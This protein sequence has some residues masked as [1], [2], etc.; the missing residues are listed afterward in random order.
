M[1]SVEVCEDDA[2][3]LRSNVVLRRTLDE[4]RR[5]LKNAELFC[6]AHGAKVRRDMMPDSVGGR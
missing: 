4:F 1:A 5:N 3:D 2:L 6:G